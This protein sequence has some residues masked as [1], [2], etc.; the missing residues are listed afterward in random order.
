MPFDQVLVTLTTRSRKMRPSVAVAFLSK[1]SL[2]I[3]IDI[4]IPGQ[5]EDKKL[6]ICRVWC[7]C[8][9]LP[10][11]SFPTRIWHFDDPHIGRGGAAGAMIYKDFYEMWNRGLAQCW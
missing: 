5:N 9:D 8:P 2:I 4:T 10:F 1:G 11:P 3:T 7:T 6:R